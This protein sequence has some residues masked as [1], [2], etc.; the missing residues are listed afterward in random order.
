MNKTDK[1]FVAGHNGLVGSAILRKLRNE[2]FANILTFDRRV[3]DLTNNIDVNVLFANY[4]PDYVFLAAAKVGGIIDNE[5]K[6]GEYIYENLLIQSNI[7]HAAKEYGV[8]KLLFLGSSCIYPKYA[9]QPIKEEY[10]LSDKLESTN[11]SYAIAK[12]AGIEMCKAYNKQ[13]GTNFISVMPTNLY[14]E[15]DN[16][17]LPN[18][19][20]LPSLMMKFHKAKINSEKSVTLY[21]DGSPLREFLHADDLADALLFLMENYDSSE[22][23]NIGTSDEVRIKVLAEY[24]ADVIGYKGD[25]IY[26]GELSGT[27]RKLLDST[28]LNNLGWKPSIDLKDGIKQTYEWFLLNY[29]TIRK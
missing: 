4:R 24:I 28:K 23:I 18:A 20:V 25:I 10:L 29:N 16:F 12:I 14:G 6:S 8:K 13:Y 15:N 19:H 22:I 21:G 17:K 27:P 3:Y 2:N 5:N 9:F 11:S 7:I 26:N 1:I